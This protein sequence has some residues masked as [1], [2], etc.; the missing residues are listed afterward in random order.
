MEPAKHRKSKIKSRRKRIKRQINKNPKFRYGITLKCKNNLECSD[1]F[2]AGYFCIKTRCIQK[3]C[4]IDLH[5]PDNTKCY[6]KVCLEVTICQND[7]DCGASMICESGF[8]TSDLTEIP[9]CYLNSDCEQGLVCRDD[10]C[11]HCVE[12]NEC[13]I[14]RNLPT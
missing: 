12:T 7:L 1:L 10:Q 13:P 11:Q 2:D 14:V 3:N 6:N 4:E 9:E 8:C 5:C